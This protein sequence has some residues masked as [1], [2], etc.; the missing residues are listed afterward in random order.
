MSA[1][2]GIY[3]A[4]F[5]HGFRV[6]HAQ[7]IENIDWARD[8]DGKTIKN[9]GLVSLKETLRDYFMRSKV[10][11]S[12]SDVNKE[13]WLLEQE[14][15]DS[16]F[17]VLEYGIGY[18]GE[19]PEFLT[20]EELKNIKIENTDLPPSKNILDSL[21]TKIS[22]LKKEPVFCGDNKT[23]DVYNKAIDDVLGVLNKNFQ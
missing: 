22:K 11:K 21:K 12:I 6:I 3:I 15:M 2:N 5:P 18:I 17:P 13:A 8:H 14:I 7:A 4:H 1:D 20:E 16:D 19:L 10:F 23:K 9:V